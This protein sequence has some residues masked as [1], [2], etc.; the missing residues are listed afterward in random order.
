MIIIIEVRFK[1]NIE[2]GIRERGGRGREEI[3]EEK[4]GEKKQEEKE[5]EQKKEEEE[6]K[7]EEEQE[8][9]EDKEWT[10]L[11]PIF[12]RGGQNL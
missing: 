3:E 9:T 12:G 5:A 4:K 11:S 7:E 10:I 6:V 1:D 8:D 2:D